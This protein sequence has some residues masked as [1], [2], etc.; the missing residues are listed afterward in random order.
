MDSQAAKQQI[1]STRSC[2]NAFTSV[3]LVITPTNVPTMRA[4]LFANMR[5]LWRSLPTIKQVVKAQCEPSR[6][7]NN[8]MYSAR[9]PAHAARK[10]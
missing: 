3:K 1:K 4:A 6:F 2:A 10:A 5:P 8:E 9:Q 7:S